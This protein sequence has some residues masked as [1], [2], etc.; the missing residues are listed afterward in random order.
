[1]EEMRISK[2]K[3]EELISCVTTGCASCPL[4]YECPPDDR[5]CWEAI[6]DWVMEED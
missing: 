6:M 3:L 2:K 4:E 5:T 1:M